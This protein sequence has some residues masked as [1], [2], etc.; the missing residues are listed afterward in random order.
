MFKCKSKLIITV[1]KSEFFEDLSET[2]GQRREPL[3]DDD[4]ILNAKVGKKVA[5]EHALKNVQGDDPKN[6]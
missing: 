5:G 1:T 6:W 2:T 4:E 3:P